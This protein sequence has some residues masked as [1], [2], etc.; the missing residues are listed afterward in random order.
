MTNF[1]KFIKPEYARPISAKKSVIPPKITK[2]VI[3]GLTRIVR[4]NKELEAHTLNISDIKFFGS[5]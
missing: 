1:P 3:E 2:D 4:E 5:S